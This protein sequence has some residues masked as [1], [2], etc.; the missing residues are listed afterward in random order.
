MRAQWDPVSS[1]ADN[2]PRRQERNNQG[3]ATDR[4]ASSQRPNYTR[5]NAGNYAPLE[6]RCCCAHAVLDSTPVSCFVPAWG[7]PANRHT[8]RIVYRTRGV[9]AAVTPLVPLEQTAWEN[10]RPSCSAHTRTRHHIWTC[11]LILQAVSS[12]SSSFVQHTRHL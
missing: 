4:Q 7:A 1:L 2:Q 8:K 6:M 3:R 10:T 5:S 12:G 11:D 9:H